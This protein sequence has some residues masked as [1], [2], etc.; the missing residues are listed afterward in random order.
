MA[1]REPPQEFTG[2]DFKKLFCAGLKAARKK[3]GEI[4]SRIS[5]EIDPDVR[6]KRALQKKYEQFVAA[7][8]K[9]ERARQ[10]VKDYVDDLLNKD[11]DAS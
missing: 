2:E 11:E 7:G 6:M 9:P 1:E 5:H 4:V 8:M 10:V 3:G